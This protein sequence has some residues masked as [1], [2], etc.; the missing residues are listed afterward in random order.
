M[1]NITDP[2]DIETIAVFRA[3]N[4]GDMLCA[5]PAL[6][7]LRA[8]LPRA[9]IIYIGL[10]WSR[11]FFTRFRRYLDEFM[12]FPGYPGLPEMPADIRRFPAFLKGLQDSGYDLVLQMHG[13]GVLTNPL[14]AL[15][16]GAVMAGFF[17]EG[18]YFPPDGL[19]IPYPDDL[20][21]IRR[22]LKLVESLDAPSRGEELEFPLFG[23]DAA[24]LD[25]LPEAA[26][27]AP[28][29]YLIVHPGA[30]ARARR[31]LAERFARA[32]DELSEGRLTVVITGSAGERDV[33]ER[34][35]E[36]MKSP[37]LNLAGRTTLGALAA[38]LRNARLLVANDT[39]IAHLAD[40]LRVPSVIVFTASDPVRWAPLDRGLHAAVRR[41]IPCR[42]C[43]FPVCPIGHPCARE[44]SVE[45]VVSE[46]R[47]LLEKHSFS[48]A[49]P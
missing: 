43:E 26:G 7:A 8:W 30:R 32:C 9:R 4:L 16:G 23:S 14:A 24:D 48:P 33:A 13:N 44:L 11:A 6:R 12:E 36:R 42:P 15:F 27:L 41:E 2:A 17:A 40:A 19:S 29:R 3:L 22:C 35:R 20:P 18:S 49:V 31:W 1:K 21:E 38:L 37:A 5:V 34:V 10:P 25:G 46:G 47:K 39:G 45:D 28:G